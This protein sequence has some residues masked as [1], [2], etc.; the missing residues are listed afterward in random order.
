MIDGIFIFFFSCVRLPVFLMTIR[1]I[2]FHPRLG[3]ALELALGLAWFGALHFVTTPS[4]FAL[5]LVGR[6]AVSAILSLGLV[7][8]PPTFKRVWHAV[9]LI[10]FQFGLAPFFLFTDWPVAWYL[11]GVVSAVL[12]A[13]SFYVIPPAERALS[14]EIKPFRR[15][16]LCMAIITVCG[17]WSFVMALSV[18]QL[19]GWAAYWWE[20]VAGM[21][22]AALGALW[23]HWYD[24]PWT[25]RSFYG[26]G[27]FLLCMIEIGL[28]VMLTPAG[29]AVGGILL[30]WWWYFL[31]LMG[32]FYLSPAGLHIKKQLPF[33]SANFILLLL[34]VFFMVRWK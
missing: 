19:V 9:T 15:L 3:A 22:S 12:P 33:V 18:F 14:F 13:A 34:Y 30:A 26:L 29:Y 5:W 11:L 8:Y 6:V 31:W 24:V 28:V 10:L 16:G 23:W 20:V 32:R 2:S 7:Y 25:R 4:A 1:D 27:I 17:L 21:A